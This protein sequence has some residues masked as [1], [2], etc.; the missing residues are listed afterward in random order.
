MEHYLH[1]AL[2][3]FFLLLFVL[4]HLPLLPLPI[5]A[6]PPLLPRP[7]SAFKEIRRWEFGVEWFSH[8]GFKSWHSVSEDISCRSV[9]GE[10]L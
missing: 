1:F 9:K 6:P 2:N 8:P 3:A 5:P 10:R 7:I 4:F